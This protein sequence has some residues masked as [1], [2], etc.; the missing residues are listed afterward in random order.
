MKTFKLGFALILVFAVNQ[1]HAHNKRGH[2]PVYEDVA[3][4]AQDLLHY[5]QFIDNDQED[6][7]V[8]ITYS[9]KSDGK[10]LIHESSATAT[11]AAEYVVDELEG[12]HIDNNAYRVDS[13]YY[14][15]V[16]FRLM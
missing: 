12:I 15:Q 10:L 3:S 4:A 16:V 8:L 11:P 9:V 7:N 2:N 1:L 14:L 6:I 13:L 5:P